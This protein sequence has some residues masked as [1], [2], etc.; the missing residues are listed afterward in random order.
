M[1]TNSKI[2][3]GATTL[4]VALF[5]LG[6]FILGCKATDTYKLHAVCSIKGNEAI[7]TA[8]EYLCGNTFVWEIEPGQVLINGKEYTLIMSSN[9]TDADP[10][11]DIIK[12]IIAK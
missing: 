11:D 8:S 1:M 7:F 4:L 6:I 12:E 2:I 3:K 5:L 9:G 10:T